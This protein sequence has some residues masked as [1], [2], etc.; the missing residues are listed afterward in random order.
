VERTGDSMDRVLRTV[1]RLLN[2]PDR[3]GERKVRIHAIGFPKT[4]SQ[5]RYGEH[6]GVRFATFMSS[7]RM[8]RLSFVSPGRTAI[9]ARGSGSCRM[10]PLEA[11]WSSDQEKQDSNE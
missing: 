8:N 4:F 9:P 10:A 6:T 7:P 11:P 5:A 1:D 2:R 3:T